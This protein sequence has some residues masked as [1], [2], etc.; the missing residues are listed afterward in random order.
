MLLRKTQSRLN[1]KGFYRRTSYGLYLIARVDTY[2]TDHKMPFHNADICTVS[3]MKDLFNI[4]FTLSSELFV[5][6]Y[7]LLYVVFTD[8]P[9]R[10]NGSVV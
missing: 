10:H 7:S 9:L 6:L 3:S 4:V 5:M 1:V 2:S 8:L